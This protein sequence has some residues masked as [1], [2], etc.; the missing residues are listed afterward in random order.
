[1]EAAAALKEAPV[2]AQIR[3]RT[4]SPATSTTPCR[5][6]DAVGSNNSATSWLPAS[7]VARLARRGDDIMSEQRLECARPGAVPQ[8][9]LRRQEAR[10]TKAERENDYHQEEDM[11]IDPVA[12]VIIAGM[13]G[14][15]IGLAGTA[16]TVVVT[17]KNESNRHLREM[18]VKTAFDQWLEDRRFAQARNLSMP[19][20]SNYILGMMKLMELARKGR[21]TP[22]QA[23]IWLRE[24]QAVLDVAEKEATD[25]TSKK[26]GGHSADS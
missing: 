21:I 3:V 16:I 8:Q 14:A 1:L 22:D 24:V 19:P 18:I 20:L 13:G 10:H 2:A 9:E 11:T 6:P 26:L 15:I 17:Q 4:S 25:Y 5:D 23:R 12:G 7:R